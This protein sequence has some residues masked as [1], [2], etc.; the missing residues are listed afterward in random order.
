MNVKVLF[1]SKLSSK[2][3][4]LERLQLLC[5]EGDRLDKVRVQILLIQED[6]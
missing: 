6:R 1:F 5:V 2:E 4:N 3:R